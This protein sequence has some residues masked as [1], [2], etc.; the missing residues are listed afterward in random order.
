MKWPTDV[1]MQ[2]P[3]L[4]IGET[5][6]QAQI[7]DMANQFGWELAYHTHDSRRS[8]EGFPDLVLIRRPVVIYRELKTEKGVVSRAQQTWLDALVACGQDAKVW[9]PRDFPEALETLK[10]VG[11]RVL[12]A[13]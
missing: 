6:W 12:S 7:M 5:A 2:P 3:P 4:T 9:R 1:F 10:P 11:W 13:T 8:Q